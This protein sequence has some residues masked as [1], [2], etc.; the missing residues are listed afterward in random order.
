MNQER[1]DKGIAL[2]REMFG[3]QGAEMQIEAATD[4]TRPLQ[5]LVTEHCFGNI[6]QRPGFSKKDRSLLTLAMLA[7]LGRSHE[8]GI[9][10]RGALANGAT[11]EELRELFLHVSLY[12]GIP[13]S[14]DCF[15]VAQPI[16]AQHAERNA[17]EH[18]GE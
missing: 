9:H 2:R 4:F 16:L 17:G 18:H 14:V 6:W 13:A 5:E 7:A 3:P 11:E 12:C 1:F 15:I 10:T 8:I